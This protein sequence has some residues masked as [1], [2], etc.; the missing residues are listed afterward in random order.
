MDDTIHSLRVQPTFSEGKPVLDFIAEVS[1]SNSHVT[2]L[3]QPL[4]NTLDPVLN[5]LKKKRKDRKKD[6]RRKGSKTYRKKD[7]KED[8]KGDARS[9]KQKK[10]GG[11]K[12][13]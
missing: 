11:R 2:T 4:V 3:E 12:T 7:R 8:G 6:R 5:D 1:P 13:K 10:E 9:K